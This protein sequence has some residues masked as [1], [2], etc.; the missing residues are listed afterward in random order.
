MF[1]FAAIVNRWSPANARWIKMAM[2]ALGL[3]GGNGVLRPPY[4][5][6]DQSQLDEMAQMLDRFGLARIEAEA[7]E[8]CTQL[9]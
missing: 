1:R 8:F 7:K 9:A 4:L 2:K 5:L 3:P 6:P